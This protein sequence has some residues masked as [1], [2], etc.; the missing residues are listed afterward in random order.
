MAHCGAVRFR[1]LRPWMSR[2]IGRGQG[3]SS[4]P[5]TPGVAVAAVESDTPLVGVRKSRQLSSIR[6]NSDSSASTSRIGLVVAVV[7]VAASTWLMSG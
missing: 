4:S 3:T 5:P 6:M 1:S 2:S 7:G